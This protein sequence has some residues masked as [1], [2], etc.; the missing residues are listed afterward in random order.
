MRSLQEL[1]QAS[2]E[3]SV[4]DPKESWT[5]LLTTLALLAFLFAAAA[6][7]ISGV[8]RFA[9]SFG[10]GL[11]LLRVFMF[12]HDYLH[13]AIFRNSRAADWIMWP[14][15]L[16]ILNPPNVWKR[17][18]NYHHQNNAQMVTAGI[19][20]FPVMTVE[21]YERAGTWTRLR[22]RATRSPITILLG[23]FTIFLM[24]MCLKSFVTDPRRHWDSLVALILHFALA[25]GLYYVGGVSLLFYCLVFPLFVSCAL[26]AYL[27]YIQHNFPG[28]S[29]KP[30]EEW[31]FV[32]A[33]LNSSSYMEAGTILRWLT[34]NIG[35][36]HVHH[37][38]ARIPFYRLPDAMAAIPE[39]QTPERTSLRPRDVYKCLKLKLWD[40]AEDRM[41]DFR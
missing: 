37:L 18:H 40:P 25:F 13:G 2:R 28:V 6:S 31:D 19:G 38:N 12:Y 22:Y 34:G 21:Q 29:L 5:L 4:E 41:V 7:P 15:G 23:Y 27:F 16:F 3:F 24:G 17:S 26:G 33:A 30:R 1:I 10:A 39:L 9:S 35:Y 36:H 20:S 14:Y 32:F 11:V 8:L